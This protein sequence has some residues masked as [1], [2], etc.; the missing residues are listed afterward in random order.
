MNILILGPQAS[1]KGTQ[2]KVISEKLGLLHIES[3]GLLRQ[4]AKADQRL[5]EILNSGALAPNDQT[6]EVV[7]EFI[8][9]QGHGY[10]NLIFD[11]F[12]R[13]ADQY[14]L[15][16]S[17]LEKNSARLDKVIYLEVRDE[18]SQER[19][20]SRRTCKVCGNVYNLITNPPKNGDKCDCG[21]ELVQ[22]EDDQPETVK[23]RLAIFHTQTEL[24][25]KLAQE[26]G[27]LIKIDGEKPIA[28]V[29]SDILGRIS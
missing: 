19:I 27:I 4:R 29:T 13:T 17:W 3:G 8:K 15:L 6:V 11:G 7:D 20:S 14:E 1:G 18:V 26:D 28:E 23:R 24:I 22:R 16:K 5:Q 10:D 9:S 12:P 25:L 2:A 21:G